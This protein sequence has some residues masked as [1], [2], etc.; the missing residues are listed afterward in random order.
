MNLTDLFFIVLAAV[1]FGGGLVAVST[2]TMVRYTRAEDA[3][4]RPKFGDIF[5]LLL[6]L[7]FVG[8]GMWRAGIFT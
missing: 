5:W 3:G 7:A 8:Y 1:I 6:A 2:V 4:Q